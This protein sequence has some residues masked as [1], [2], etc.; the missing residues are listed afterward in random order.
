MQFTNNNRLSV[1]VSSRPSRSSAAWFLPTPV[2]LA[3]GKYFFLALLDLILTVFR[4]WDRR[5][6]KKGTANSIISSYN[7]NFTGRNDANPAT[8][9]FVTS[10]DL[11][12][13]MSIAGTLSFNPLKDELTGADGKKFKLKEPTGAGLPA[14]GY[15]PGQDTYQAPPA[16][17]ESVQVAV[18]P[19]S[20]R[21]QI[22]SP[23]E[24]WD[25][26]DA[27]NLPILI[28]CQGKTTT[29]HISMAGPWLKYRGHLD[30]ISNN[31]LIGAINEENG[32]ANKIKNALNGEYGAVPDVARDYKKNGVK[33]VVIGDWNYGEGSSREHAAL[34]PRHLGGLA[35]ITRSFARIHET[36]LKKQGMLP[37]TFSDPADYEKIGPNDRVDI[38]ATELAVGKPI[39][40]VVHP[41]NGDKAFD[42]KLSHTFN[43]GQIE[44]FKNGSALNTM[45]KDR[46]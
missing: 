2:V 36:N 18:S 14:N 11:V 30:N 35:I 43:E 20:D 7:R 37:L 34:E 16:D 22:L 42:I 46:K 10:P 32:E 33:W 23:F 15:D 38:K 3:L 40:M 45:A 29:D 12:V 28:K 13:A 19:T 6:V 24:A 21:L 17:R 26:K 8:H 39:T 5:D 41:A 44:W 31:M 4:Q 1:T 25:G 27:T 9:S